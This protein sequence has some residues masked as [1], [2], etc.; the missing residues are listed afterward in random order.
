MQN[1]IGAKFKNRNKM[2][3]EIIIG[4]D[5]DINET[6]VS[7]LFCNDKKIMLSTWSFPDLMMRLAG[8]FPIEKTLIC[9]E[10]GFLNKSNWH[11][12]SAKSK[13][14]AAEIGR[15]TGENHATAKLIIE[16][17]KNLGFDVE[18]VRPLAKVWGSNRKS[19]IS[20]KEF[21][22]KC[23]K[24]GFEFYKNQTNQEERDAGLISLAFFKRQNLK[25]DK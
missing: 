16:F 9:V 23:K 22:D 12:K 25:L 17:V 6:G 24:D 5:P 2:K 13:E 10:A 3:Y 11:I 15:R 19:K 1:V 20:H 21:V 4:I 18:E 14:I 7:V 8:Y